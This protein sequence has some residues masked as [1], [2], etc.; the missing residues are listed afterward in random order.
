MVSVRMSD[1]SGF[2]AGVAAAG[3]ALAD[4]VR[5]V[6]HEMSD[7]YRRIHAA[8]TEDPGTAGDEGEEAWAALLRQWL[9]ASYHV[10]TK[11]RLIGADGAKSPQVDVVVL[12]PSYPPKLLDKRTWIADGVAAVF[13]CKLTITPTAI[14]DTIRRSSEFGSRLQPREGSP[15]RELVSPL[16]HGLLAHSHTWK[17]P[18]SDPVENITNAVQIADLAHCDHPRNMLSV[19]CVADAGTWTPVRIAAGVPAFYGEGWETFRAAHRLPRDGGVITGYSVPELRM[20]LP[21]S[22]L[23]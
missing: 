19:I 17:K 2:D 18:G 12:K 11:G 1:P 13:E 14:T 16:V 4:W 8:A 5:Q 10:R 15:Y 7:E 23:A 3:H 22:Q 20:V 9:P 21:V 6:T